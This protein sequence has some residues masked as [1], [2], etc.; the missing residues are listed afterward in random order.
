MTTITIITA[1]EAAFGTGGTATS[2]IGWIIDAQPGK[3]ITIEPG[4]GRITVRTVE[5]TDETFAKIKLK[6]VTGKPPPSSSVKQHS[7]KQT[8]GALKRPNGARKRKRMPAVERRLRVPI[9]AA[10]VHFKD[11]DRQAGPLARAREG[12]IAAVRLLIVGD[13]LR[14]AEAEAVAARVEAVAEDDDDEQCRN[15]HEN[16]NIHIG[17]AYL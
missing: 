13:L 16:S 10:A 12:R 9:T 5:R 15:D 8:S 11:M 17:D 6:A 14:L 1:G 2:I 7:K 4:I 3:I